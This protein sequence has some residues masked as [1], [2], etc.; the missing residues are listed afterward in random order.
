MTNRPRFRSLRSSP[1]WTSRCIASRSGPRLTRNRAAR[2][3]SVSWLPGG[4]EPYMIALRSR[5]AMML[6]V[7]SRF[8]GPRP[9]GSMIVMDP[10]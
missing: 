2:S 5:R 10:S 4:S 3:A 6:A 7:D 8:T 1:S 9:P